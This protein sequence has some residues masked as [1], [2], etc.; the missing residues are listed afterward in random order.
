MKNQGGNALIVFQT[1]LYS[2][3][4]YKYFRVTQYETDVTGNK[5]IHIG[6]DKK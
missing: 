5:P 3:L 4:Q 2:I 1:D 6:R